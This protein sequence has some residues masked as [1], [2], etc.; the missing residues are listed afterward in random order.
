LSA[1]LLASAMS[2]FI[3]AAWSWAGIHWGFRRLPELV[4]VTGLPPAHARA[5]FVAYRILWHL[6]GLGLAAVL[7]L[8]AAEA[9]LHWDAPPIIVAVCMTGFFLG[10]PNLVVLLGLPWLDRHVPRPRTRS[11]T[12]LSW[13]LLLAVICTAWHLA[14]VR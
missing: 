11:A 8:A 2:L 14:R 7:L 13:V 1:F 9:L 6:G 5:F 4:H 3:A 10:G 12:F